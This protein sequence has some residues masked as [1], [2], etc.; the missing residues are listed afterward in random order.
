MMKV[1]DKSIVKSILTK[2]EDSL[3]YF[4]LVYVNDFNLSISRIKKGETFSYQKGKTFVSDKNILNRIE[5]LVIPPMWKKVRI[6]DLD[7]GH[8]QAVGRDAKGRKQY[9]YHPKWN[10]VRNKTKFVKMIDFGK[11]LPKIRARVTSD[12]NQKNWTKTKVLAL[13]VKLLEETHIRI[14]NTQY[15]KRNKTYGITTLRTR[16]INKENNKIRF[17]F[18]GKRGKEHKITLRNKKLIKLVNQCQEIPGWKLFQYYDEDGVKKEIDSSSVN[19]YIHAISGELFTAKDFRTWSASLISFNTLMDFGI[20]HDDNQ[21]KKNRLSAIDITA[22]ELGNTRNVSR[23]YY[24][25]PH[26]LKTYEDST[27]DKYFQKAE[28]DENA[29]AHFSHSENALMALLEDYS[30]VINM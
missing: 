12:L 30:P 11:N 15:A 5:T 3:S 1:I 22:K 13:I 20:E 18:V 24:I 9:R 27:I 8:L 21:N 16:H 25:H 23:K 29:Y 10:A 4:D 19:D 17:E 26:I 14:G 28:N 2:P 7:N 6:S